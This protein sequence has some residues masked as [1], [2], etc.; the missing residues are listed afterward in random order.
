ADCH[1]TIDDELHDLDCR[2]TT[3]D[4]FFGFRNQFLRVYGLAIAADW[5]QGSFMYSLYKSTHRL[6]ESMV[7]ALFATGFVSGG[8]SAIFV[9]SL[10]DRFGRKR[11]CLAYCV[12]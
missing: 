5:L 3:A 12:L 2:E 7:A 4:K 9:G 6:P 1:E 11:A 10:A 8:V